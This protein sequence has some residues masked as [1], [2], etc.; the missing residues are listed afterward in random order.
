VFNSVFR[1]YH[2]GGAQRP[3]DG[4]G[5]RIMYYYL[6]VSVFVIINSRALEMRMCN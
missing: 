2:A 3:G 5:A 4:P 1:P 6:F